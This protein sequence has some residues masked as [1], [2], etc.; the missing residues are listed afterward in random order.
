[1]ADSREALLAIED[2]LARSTRCARARAGRASVGAI[3]L[4]PGGAVRCGSC[5]RG[6][7]CWRSRERRDGV[8][9]LDLELREDGRCCW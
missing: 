3:A 5:A 1:M 9:P 2:V 4:D 8:V 7:R 6:I